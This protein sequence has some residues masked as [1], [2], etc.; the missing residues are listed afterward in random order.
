KRRG[1]RMQSLKRLA[2]GGLIVTMMVASGFA[3]SAPKS[4]ATT[5]KKASTTSTT[6]TSTSTASAPKGATITPEDL[7]ALR[8][9]IEAQQIQI[10]QLRQELSQRDE[11]V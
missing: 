7:K 8:D 10:N 6:T 11:A 1:D 4:K 9:A 3:Q 5:K 2:T